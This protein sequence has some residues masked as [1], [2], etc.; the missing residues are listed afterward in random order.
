MK[1]KENLYEHRGRPRKFE[2]GEI[3]EWRFRI[4]ANLLDELK[5]FARA[6]KQSIND[7][8]INRLME[9]LNYRPGV[10][11]IKTVKG[12]ML[13]SLAKKFHQ[14]IDETRPD[15]LGEKK[16]RNPRKEKVHAWKEGKRIFI[17]G[18]SSQYSLRLPE[19]LANEIRVMA[20][21]NRRSLNDEMVTRIL[22]SMGY[23]TECFLGKGEKIDELKVL[24]LEFE[25][26]IK[27]K[28]DK[29]ESTN[30]PWRRDNKE[31]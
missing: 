29:V 7:E 4:P 8:I 11:S 27:E 5:T 12:E 15:A 3:I 23:F 19:N 14:W 26:Y 6:R 10:P 25:S 20:C 16:D 21:F 24:A 30:I 28:I 9:S 31:D 2:P 13:I 17:P 1:V 22:D 18:D